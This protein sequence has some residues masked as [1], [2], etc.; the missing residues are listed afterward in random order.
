MMQIELL[1]EVGEGSL[2]FRSTDRQGCLLTRLGNISENKMW[3]GI[4]CYRIAFVR[5][6][7]RS[8]DRLRQCQKIH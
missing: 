4:L 8:A 6:T 5:I 3:D 1:P 2:S 7:L